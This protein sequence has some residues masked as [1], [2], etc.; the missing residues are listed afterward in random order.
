MLP[1]VQAAK[2][3]DTLGIE[4]IDTT[5]RLMPPPGVVK[6]LPVQQFDTIQTEESDIFY[7]IQIFSS[8][9]GQK[10]AT[11]IRTYLELPNQ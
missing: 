11:S 3:P 4:P 9:T 5:R 10:S 1:K 8:S 7:R 6:K 2:Q